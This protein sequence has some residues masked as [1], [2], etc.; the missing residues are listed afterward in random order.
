MSTKL[1]SVFTI[2]KSAEQKRD[3]ILGNIIA[4]LVERKYI[5]DNN[6]ASEIIKTLTKPNNPEHD[7]SKYTIKIN[8]YETNKEITTLIIKLIPYKITS[9]SKTYGISDFL[10]S[11]RDVPKIL[12]VDEVSKRAMSIIKTY[13]NVEVFEEEFLMINWQEHVFCP[14]H[15]KLNRQE[16]QAVLEEYLMKKVQM[17]RILISDPGS[18]YYNAKIGDVFRI[19]RPSTRSGI[20][21]FYRLV[22]PA[23]AK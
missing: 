12:V 4:M 14:K 20:T 3:T 6:V 8:N 2:E 11:D 22:V 10:N 5:L 17:P 7:D 21:R 15:E 19:T 16:K 18:I 1:E 13:K 9:V 23:P